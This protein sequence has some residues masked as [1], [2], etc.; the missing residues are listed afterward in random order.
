M[1]SKIA[2]LLVL[3]LPSTTDPPKK[4]VNHS[5]ILLRIPHTATSWGT[6]RMSD[7]SR[8]TA[9][10][11][12][13]SFIET[14]PREDRIDDHAVEPVDV[15]RQLVRVVGVGVRVRVLHHVVVHSVGRI[16]IRQG[17]R[18]ARRWAW[19]ANQHGLLDL[20]VD[21]RGEL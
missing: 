7:W 21:C 17:W 3:G 10:R 9:R 13:P 2:Y 12:P 1:A 6:V 15:D 8:F 4:S 19:A 5:R 16:H 11:A 20:Q 18:R 14:S